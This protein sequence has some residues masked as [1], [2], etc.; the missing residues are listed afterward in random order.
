MEALTMCL[1]QARCMIVEASTVPM[2]IPRGRFRDV[3]F[4]MELLPAAVDFRD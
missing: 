1:R 4:S 3:V 2:G